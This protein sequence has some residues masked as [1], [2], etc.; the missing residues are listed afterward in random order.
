MPRSN[1]LTQ[2]DNSQE[3]EQY[4]HSK[5]LVC[6]MPVKW[7]ELWE[8]MRKE[9]T[10]IGVSVPSIDIQPLVLS[11][12]EADDRAKNQRFRAQLKYVIEAGLSQ[13]VRDFLSELAPTD[14]LRFSDS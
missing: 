7:A 9:A 1:S 10:A 6:P 3:L 2:A 14:W 12:W 13:S 11:G 5:E 4:L 8:L